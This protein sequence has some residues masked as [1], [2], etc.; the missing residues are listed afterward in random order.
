MTTVNPITKPVFWIAPMICSVVFLG[1]IAAVIVS[2]PPI[3]K[4]NHVSVNW[5]M[6]I[7]ACLGTVSSLIALAAMIFLPIKKHM[8]RISFGIICVEVVLTLF[9]SVALLYGAFSFFGLI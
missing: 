6:L 1:Y 3:V 8:G 5:N 9:L 7:I 2:I 4:S